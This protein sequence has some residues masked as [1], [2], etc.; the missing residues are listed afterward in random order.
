[1][2]KYIVPP[3][4]GEIIIRCKKCHTL[5][6]PEFKKQLMSNLNNHWYEPCPTCGWEHNS[7]LERIPLWRY[8]LIKWFR[9]TDK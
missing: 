2:A 5:Y 1:M 8:N 3:K 4:M 6:V 9:G 7:E